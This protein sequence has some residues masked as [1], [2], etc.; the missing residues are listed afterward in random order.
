MV[1]WGRSD[2][3]KEKDMMMRSGEKKICVIFYT[4]FLKYVRQV[5][6]S[7]YCNSKDKNY[8]TTVLPNENNKALSHSPCTYLI[9]A[10]KKCRAKKQTKERGKESNTDPD[11]TDRH[12]PF[13]PFRYFPYPPTFIVLFPVG[14][15]CRHPCS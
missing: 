10:Y 7:R 4:M 12:S 3:K 2:K 6:R 8:C 1:L 15:R 13:P 9:Q 14:A 5:I 11:C